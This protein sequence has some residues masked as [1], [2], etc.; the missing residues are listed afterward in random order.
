MALFVLFLRELRER[1]YSARCT[2]LGTIYLQRCF[3]S[4]TFVQNAGSKE[5]FL[6]DGAADTDRNGRHVL[7]DEFSVSV[8]AHVPAALCSYSAFLSNQR[9]F[10]VLQVG[11]RNLKIHIF[12]L[13]D[14]TH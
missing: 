5:Q 3:G 1:K 9:S 12:F 6:G 11:M 13:L 10:C 7:I 4:D 8:H 14:K 2:H